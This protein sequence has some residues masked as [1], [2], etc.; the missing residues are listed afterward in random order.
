MKKMPNSESDPDGA[1]TLDDRVRSGEYEV[2][3]AILKENPKH[4]HTFS[5]VTIEGLLDTL[6][7]L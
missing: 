3:V 1:D 6:V 2:P 4:K 7:Q 5:P